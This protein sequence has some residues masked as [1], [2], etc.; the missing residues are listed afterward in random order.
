MAVQ[1]QG[2]A[3]QVPEPPQFGPAGRRHLRGEDPP[4]QELAGGVLEAVAV[5]HQGQGR[6]AGIAPGQEK[7]EVRGGVREVGP[8]GSCFKV[9]VGAGLNPSHGFSVPKR[10]LGTRILKLPGS[11]AVLILPGYFLASGWTRVLW[12]AG[13]GVGPQDSTRFHRNINL[14]RIWSIP[15]HQ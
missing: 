10:S 7:A 9:G 3:R 4:V 11:Q 8:P 2:A 14:S 12:P 13:Q 15:N 6:G 5:P 1:G